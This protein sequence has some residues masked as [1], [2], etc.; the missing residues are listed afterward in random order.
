MAAELERQAGKF[1]PSKM[2]NEYAK[3]VKEL[4]RAKV[5]QRAPEISVVPETGKPPKVINIMAALKESMQARGTTASFAVTSL[6]DL[7][8]V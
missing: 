5:E 7:A 3:A 4:V 8:A 6:C 1:E 2:P